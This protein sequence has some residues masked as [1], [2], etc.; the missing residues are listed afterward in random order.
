MPP[1]RSAYPGGAYP[2]G[3]DP[4]RVE[5]DSRG[6]PAVVVAWI[7]GIIALGL[8]IGAAIVGEAVFADEG[9]QAEFSVARACAAGQDPLVDPCLG[10]VTGT[11]TGA[12]VDQGKNSDSL[13][14]TVAADGRS[15]EMT[16]NVPDDGSQ[17]YAAIVYSGDS[18]SLQLWRGIAVSVDVDNI[19][20]STDDAPTTVYRDM[21]F[22]LPFLLGFLLLLLLLPAYVAV[23]VLN[24]S[25]AYNHPPRYPQPAKRLVLLTLLAAVLLLLGGTIAG[26]AVPLSGV[27]VVVA[28]DLALVFAGLAT[29]ALGT[30]RALRDEPFPVDDQVLF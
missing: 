20:A 17:T 30:R 21:V 12:Y 28:L 1:K 29:L 24:G 18:A 2:G 13:D 10:I 25:I 7:A 22:T 3:L 26:A 11:V 8:A 9:P 16:V 27:L 14:L 23:R 4:W 19:S 5:K 15:W 6:R